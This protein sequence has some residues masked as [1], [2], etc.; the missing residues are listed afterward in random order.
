VSIEIPIDIQATLLTLPADLKPLP[1]QPVKNELATQAG[2]S[3]WWVR[4]ITLSNSMW[5]NRAP[6]LVG[7]GGFMLNVGELACAVQEVAN[8]VVEVDMDAWAPSL[9]SLPALSSKQTET[10]TE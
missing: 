6:V 2:K 5:G 10:V 1:L 8:L 3:L 7:D 9:P 4:D